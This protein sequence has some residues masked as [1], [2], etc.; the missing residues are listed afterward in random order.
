VQDP[1]LSVYALAH[2]RVHRTCDEYDRRLRRYS[3]EGYEPLQ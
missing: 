3:L 1:K 2:G